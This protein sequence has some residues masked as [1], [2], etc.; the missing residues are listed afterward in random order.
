V[1]THAGSCSLDFEPTVAT[2]TASGTV[3][4]QVAATPSVGWEPRWSPDGRRILSYTTS[5][6]EASGF[7]LV[8][9]DAVTRAE[10]RLTVGDDGAHSWSSDGETVIFVRGRTQ[11]RRVPAAG[12]ESTVIG[13]GSGP[14]ASPTAPL[15]AFIRDGA[16]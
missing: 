11:M 6:S 4:R 2:V 7:G 8:V 16:L 1:H 12:G 3:R 14:E 9:V 10:T 13:R 5:L 15:V